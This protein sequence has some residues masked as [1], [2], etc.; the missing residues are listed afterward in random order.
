MPTVTTNADNVA[1]VLN[2]IIA[3]GDLICEK[4]VTNSLT[5]GQ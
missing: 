3:A 5:L 2:E 4:G 1:K